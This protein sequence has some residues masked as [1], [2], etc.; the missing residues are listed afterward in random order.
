MSVD[1]FGRHEDILYRRN[2][3]GSSGEGFGLTTKG[4]YNMDNKLIRNMGEPKAGKDA[5]TL[6]YLQKNCFLKGQSS[7]IECE[8]RTLRNISPPT[9]ENDAVS[10]KYMR[11]EALM[12][13]SDGNFDGKNKLVR[14]LKYPVED[15]DAATRGF[16]ESI[17]QIKCKEIDD[18]IV[19]LENVIFKYV[20][21][22]HDMTFSNTSSPSQPPTPPL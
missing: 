4:H 21:R 11:T 2:V 13:S 5:V 1:K 15:T 16:V 7:I 22:K 9:L 14:N 6:H 19:Q 17:V 18:K 10:L 12:S 20:H 3:R 8:R